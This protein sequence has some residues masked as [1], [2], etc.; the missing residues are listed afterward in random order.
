MILY[1]IRVH[2]LEE[3]TKFLSLTERKLQRHLFKCRQKEKPKM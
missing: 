1:I 2:T 3:L